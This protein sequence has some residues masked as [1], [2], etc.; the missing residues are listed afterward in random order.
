MGA[1]FVRNAAEGDA[2]LDELVLPLGIVRL[3]LRKDSTHSGP[4]NARVKLD[5]PTALAVGYLALRRDADFDVGESLSAG[6]P[7][8]YTRSGRVEESWF[9]YQAAGAIWLQGDPN[10]PD[11]DADVV[12]VFA[13][14]RVHVLQYDFLSWAIPADGLL[15]DRLPGGAWIARHLDLG[16][17]SVAW[18]LSNLLIPYDERPWEHEANFLSQVPAPG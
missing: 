8:F 4:L 5:V 16:V 3:H 6:V 1:S 9:G 11:L 14:E 17:I 12:D 10:D 15:T 18:G 13:H 7:V 2:V